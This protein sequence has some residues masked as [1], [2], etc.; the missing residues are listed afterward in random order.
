M[1]DNRRYIIQFVFLLIGVIY[2][3]RL[4]QLQI[5][6][7]S[8]KLKALVTSSERVVQYPQRGQIYDRNGKLIVYNTPV[9]DLMV[10]PKK[11][12]IEDTL[13][14]CRLLEITRD[15]FDSLVVKMKKEKGYSR[16]RPSIFM[17]QLSTVDFAKIQDGLIDYPGFYVTARTIRHYPYKSMANTLGYIGEINQRQLEKQEG[18]YYSQGDYV[19]LSGLEASYENVLRE[20]CSGRR[21]ARRERRFQEWR[22]GYQC[23]SRR[24]SDLYRRH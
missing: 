13:A 2:L 4:F 12:K 10:I 19:G 8:Y 7:D 5:I 16:V 22:P 9:Y 18:N 24:K 11:A 14:F 17:G 6:E 1:N 20:V 3:V 21:K 15:G 23:S